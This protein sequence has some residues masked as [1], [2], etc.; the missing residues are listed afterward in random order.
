VTGNPRKFAP[1]AREAERDGR[2]GI[3]HFDIAP[4][5]IN[6]A[7]PV[8]LGI[9]GDA[10]KNLELL[11][12]MIER[13]PRRAWLEQIA[14]WKKK[15]PFRYKDDTRPAHMKPQAVI[16]ELY[17]QTGGKAILTTGVGQHQM[18][19]AQFYRFNRPRQFITSG[20]AG[21]MGFGV[22]ASI[23]AKLGKPSEPV[24]N[25]DGD[26]SFSMT[27]MEMATA[28]QYNIAAKTII[29]N[30]DFQGMVKQWQDLF[31]KER[32]SHTEMHNPDFVMLAEALH[33]KGIR[34]HSKAELP[35]KMKEFLEHDGPAVMDAIVEKHE[36]VYPM[37]PAAKSVD[38][39]VLGKFD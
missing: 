14:G 36:H 11:L 21:T 29:L 1:A 18:W 13:R 10:R 20:G 34:V 4:E 16:E 27:A 3:I 6:K 7:V 8:T 23:G 24:I 5:N 33:C 30:N 12:P 22:P 38:E 37:I 32:Y 26:G 31:Y 17:R 9:E 35:E 2:G 28:A 15:H 39:M 25:I 19:A